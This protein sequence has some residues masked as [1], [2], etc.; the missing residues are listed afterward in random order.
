M[1]AAAVSSVVGRLRIRRAKS[2]PATT[3]AM[4]ATGI[5]T[6][7]PALA[8]VERPLE[9]DSESEPELKPALPL[10]V[11]EGTAC[12]I[13]WVGVGVGVEEAEVVVD[14]WAASVR[15]KLWLFEITS[16]APET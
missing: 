6:P 1:A 9:P 8:P 14:V 13:G 12:P 15:L 2:T 5:A 3:P 7:M 11:A 16:G 4:T 10:D